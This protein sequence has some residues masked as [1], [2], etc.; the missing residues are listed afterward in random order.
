MTPESVIYLSFRRFRFR[1]EQAPVMR[2]LV[3][4]LAKCRRGFFQFR[5]SSTLQAVLKVGAGGTH[6][7]AARAAAVAH[8]EVH[9]EEGW[10]PLTVHSGLSTVIMACRKGMACRRYVRRSMVVFALSKSS[11]SCGSHTH[12]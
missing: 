2:K 4:V 10:Y 6:A 7:I 9:V 1:S 12:S 8:E 3:D 5:A 11:N